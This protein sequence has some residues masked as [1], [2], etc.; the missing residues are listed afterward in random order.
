MLE[1]PQPFQFLINFI[2]HLSS[3]S[4]NRPE[5]SPVLHYNEIIIYV[6]A[7][8]IMRVVVRFIDH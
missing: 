8:A 4:L 2:Q 6:R 5:N 3:V 7:S 1:L